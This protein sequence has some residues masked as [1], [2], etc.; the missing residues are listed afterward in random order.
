MRF[1]IFCVHFG[2]SS[3]RLLESLRNVVQIHLCLHAN[4]DYTRTMM[5]ISMRYVQNRGEFSLP[6]SVTCIC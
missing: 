6:Y 3:S 1:F 4:A 2:A 5:S